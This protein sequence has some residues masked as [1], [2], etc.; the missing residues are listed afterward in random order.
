VHKIRY[1]FID[2]LRFIAAFTVAIT[3]LII[4]QKGL[5]VNL[6]IISSMSVE[7]F[8]II[9]GFVLAPQILKTIKTKNLI[10]YK[11]FLIRRW[12]RT[13]PLYLLSLILTSILLGNLFTFDFFK[14]FFF[15]QNFFNNSLNVDFFSIAWSLSVEEWFYIIFPLF[16]LISFKI[17][18]LNKA[19]H[20][21]LVTIFFILIIFLIRFFYSDYSEWGSN[22]RRIVIFRL[23][24]IAFGFIL[25][26]VKDKIILKKINNM[27]LILFFLILSI[28]VFKI[29]EMNISDNPH[30][31]KVIFHYTV[32]LWGS[33][34]VFLCYIFDKYITNTSFINFN[35]YLGKISYSIYLFHLMLIYIISTLNFLSFSL[36]LGLFIF[37]QIILSTLL[38]HYFE[39]PILNSRPNYSS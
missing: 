15:V 6:E 3:H 29:F 24:S 19:D 2:Q 26:F 18:N 12:Y 30:L 10:N 33:S 22:V 32:A 21:V 14:Y 1:S 25:F 13:I 37:F 23:D 16:L 9:S 8:F 27:I 28:F 35:L 17:F 38:Y 20:V 4:V 5:N 11:I 36:L 31:F 34:I 39:K 7:I